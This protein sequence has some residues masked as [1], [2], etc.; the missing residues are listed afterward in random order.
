VQP[1][2]FPE[3]VDACHEAARRVVGLDNP[4]REAAAS[5]SFAPVVDAL[6]R[7]RDIDVLSSVTSPAS[8][9]P[10]S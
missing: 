1:V 7:L 9:I 3:Y 8:T 2:V 5:W 4:I 10:D 6:I